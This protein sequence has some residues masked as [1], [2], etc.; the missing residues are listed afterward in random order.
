MLRRQFFVLVF[1]LLALSVAHGGEGQWAKPFPDGRPVARHRLAVLY[2]APGGDSKSHM[3]RDVG[4][5]WLD[6]PLVPP[7]SLGRR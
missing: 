5:A 3:K 2:D 6:L 4:L 7:S 1:I